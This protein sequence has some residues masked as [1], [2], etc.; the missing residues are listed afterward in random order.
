M[1]GI[2]DDEV[3]DEADV[4]GPDLELKWPPETFELTLRKPVIF[5]DLSYDALSLREPTDR[6][7]ELIMKAPEGER[8]RTAIALVAGIPAGAVALMGIGD[9]VRAEAYLLSFFDIGQVIG[10]S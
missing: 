7:F 5:K 8:R 9:T 4:V 3:R 6:E 2:D 10:V 1:S